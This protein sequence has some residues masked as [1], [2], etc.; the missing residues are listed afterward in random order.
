MLGATLNHNR[1]ANL[2]DYDQNVLSALSG[3]SHIPGVWVP[4]K[5]VVPPSAALTEFRTSPGAQTWSLR[6]IE[7]YIVEFS[8]DQLGSR[9]IQK[10]LQTASRTEV[11]GVFD[12]IYPSD[13]L[14]LMQ[15]PFGNYVIQ[16]LFERGTQ[17]E[18]TSLASLMKHNVLHLSCSPYGY[19]V[20]QKAI[21]SILPEHQASL[22]E[23]LQPD[24]IT[25][26]LDLNGNYVIQRILQR[27]SPDRLTFVLDLVGRVWELA[28][29]RFGNRVLKCC[30]ECL[31]DDLSRPL[32]D[33]LL[34]KHLPCLVLD[35]FDFKNHSVQFVLERV[36]A[37]DKALI[38][39]QLSSQ[40]LSLAKHKY[41]SNV[42]EKALLKASPDARR[43]IIDEIMA[44]SAVPDA[45]A[46]SSL[47]Y[48]LQ[49][50]LAVAEGRQKETLT[51]VVRT[52][53]GDLGSSIHQAPNHR[54]QLASIK[55][56]LATD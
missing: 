56:E 14:H 12:E 6:D 31:P 15:H 2:K 3:S 30:I 52:G 27:V 29:H 22:G 43:L 38:V 24:I 54:K 21:E 13:A 40:F 5:S 9:F 34:A 41:G 55:R 51:K 50:A 8:A 26:A 17:R 20:V 46:S 53:L 23:E 11:K 28:S 48:V 47:D 36:R 35:R 42:C 19:R 32:L 37:E 4:H 10:Q 49:K 7:G 25:C 45:V 39:T 44:P 33:E 16:N 18:K 1:Q